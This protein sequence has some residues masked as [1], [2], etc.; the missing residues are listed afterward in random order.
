[1]INRHSSRRRPQFVATVTTDCRIKARFEVG[2]Y[3]VTLDDK[4][5]AITFRDLQRTGVVNLEVVLI[6]ASHKSH[7][8]P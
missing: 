8:F 6:F 1:M 7:L 2:R 4:V 3:L 5:N